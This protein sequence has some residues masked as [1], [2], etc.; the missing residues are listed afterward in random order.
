MAAGHVAE[1]RRQPFIDEAEIK[2]G[3]WAWVK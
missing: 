3:Q 1:N 2:M